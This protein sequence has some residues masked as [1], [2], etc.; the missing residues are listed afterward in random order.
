MLSTPIGKGY[1]ILINDKSLWGKYVL[2]NA[3]FR[4]WAQIRSHFLLLRT[5][6]QAM[7]NLG[8]PIIFTTPL[9]TPRRMVH[10]D[11]WPWCIMAV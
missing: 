2:R 9:N 3:D 11:R 7:Q 5:P 1:I 10:A 8:Y 6:N 4:I